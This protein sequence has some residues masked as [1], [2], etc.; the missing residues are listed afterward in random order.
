MDQKKPLIYFPKTETETKNQQNKR[1]FRIEHG[2]K[3]I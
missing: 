3:M 2:Y 1:K